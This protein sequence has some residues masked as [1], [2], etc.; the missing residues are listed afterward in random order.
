MDVME[1]DVTAMG[2]LGRR[3]GR[4]LKAQLVEKSRGTQNNEKGHTILKPPFWFLNLQI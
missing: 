2:P 1:E 4:K 3:D